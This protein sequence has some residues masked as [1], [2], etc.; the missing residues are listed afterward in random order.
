MTGMAIYIE[1]DTVEYHPVGM[2]V[3]GDHEGRA[4][5][6][7][8]CCDM[9]KAVVVVSIILI[10]V[11]ML[12]ITG[13]T[14]AR[15]GLLPLL[16]LK[17]TDD[18]SLVLDGDDFIPTMIDTASATIVYI[19]YFLLLGV[20]FAALSLYGAINF[21]KYFVAANAI[22]LA[23]TLVLTLPVG[24]LVSAFILGMCIYPH[25]YLIY[26][27]HTGVITKENY[28]KEERSC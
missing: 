10:V 19:V 7:C 2:V 13:L 28:A 18:S 4:S 23:L 12:L 25:A 26:Y 20:V 24:W 5:R 16:Q 3:Q 15:K 11:D 6:L 9:R 27:L 21:N 1:P 17:G 22:F 14:F 8:C